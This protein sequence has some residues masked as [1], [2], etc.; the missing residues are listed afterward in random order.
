MADLSREVNF[1]RTL[2]KS[3]IF[4]T[5]TM[6]AMGLVRVKNNLFIYIPP[7]TKTTLEYSKKKFIA[8]VLVSL[9]FFMVLSYTLLCLIKVLVTLFPYTPAID[10]K[11][12]NH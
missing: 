4:V 11:V 12:P 2:T 7:P 1:Q 8:N 9:V 5:N 3:S 10:N 6:H